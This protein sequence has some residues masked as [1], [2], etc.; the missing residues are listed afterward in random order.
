[1]ADTPR[2]DWA[3]EDRELLAGLVDSGETLA[4]VLDAWSY[5]HDR[6]LLRHEWRLQVGRW[7]ARQWGETTCPYCRHNEWQI[8]AEPAQVESVVDYS[9]VL[10]MAHVVC[11]HC[12]HVVF[13]SASAIRLSK[14]E[15]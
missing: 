12:G 7:L 15:G 4:D 10:R 1:M 14:G 3:S 11:G 5:E 6:D 13:I 9:R 8:E 2:E